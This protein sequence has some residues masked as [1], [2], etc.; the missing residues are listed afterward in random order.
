MLFVGQ[1]AI[2]ASMCHFLAKFVALTGNLGKIKSSPM[3]SIAVQCSPTLPCI[4]SVADPGW[5]GGMAPCW[6]PG[7]IMHIR[8]C[9]DQLLIAIR[10]LL[11]VCDHVRS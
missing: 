7:N 6:R 11:I 5:V 1:A 2:R 8:A 4:Q 9:L 3:L 10:P